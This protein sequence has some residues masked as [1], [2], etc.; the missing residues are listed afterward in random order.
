[1]ISSMDDVSNNKLCVITQV[2]LFC[3]AR[4]SGFRG[5]YSFH[6]DFGGLFF[7]YFFSNTHF[8]MIHKNH[9]TV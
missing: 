3:K 8:I 7:K 2:A 4:K 1:M 9:N 5:G 6:F